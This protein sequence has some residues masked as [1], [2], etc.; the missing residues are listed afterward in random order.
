MPLVKASINDVDPPHH[1]FSKSLDWSTEHNPDGVPLVHGAFDQGSCGSC[2]AFAA[3]GSI[4]TNL[5]NE[6]MRIERQVFEELTLS[7]Q[8][9][10]DCD[11]SVNEGC[12]GGNPLLAFFY[13]HKHGLVPWEEY[14]YEGQ[15]PSCRK[16]KIG[17]PIATVESWGL[18]HKNH[19]DL[20]EYALLYVGP[21]AVGIYGADPAFINYGG[22][23]FDSADCDQTANHALLIVGYDQEDVTNENGDV[24]T[25]RYWI[26]R[27][28]WGEGWGE[29]G[30]A[31]IK[32]GPGGKGVPG[33]CGIARS[34]SVALGGLY[35]Q[36]RT[37][38][39]K[40]KDKLKTTSRYRKGKY[41]VSYDTTASRNGQNER[42]HPSCHSMFNGKSDYLNA[43]CERFSIIYERYQSMFLALIC[44]LIALIAIIPLGVSLRRQHRVAVGHCSIRLD[45][46]ADH[47]SLSVR[48][49]SSSRGMLS[50]RTH[51]LTLKDMYADQR[52]QEEETKRPRGRSIVITSPEQDP[53]RLEPSSTFDYPSD[54]ETKPPCST[55]NFS[56]LK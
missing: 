41:V 30:F 29:N 25:I 9:L 36:N 4:E 46:S 20:I 51:L 56:S 5:I 42:N 53:F 8:E 2:W 49:G 6:S 7:I 3:T 31:R 10:L 17:N 27:N 12:V 40:N 23:I 11:V 34:P 52:K 44:M 19:E 37:E 39:L 28:S 21:V 55:E 48:S 13:I 26:A 14:P 45:R 38:P 15:L 43:G 33:V 18:L 24:E 16:D 50:E 22:G 1:R 54:D 32:R 47:D 35:R